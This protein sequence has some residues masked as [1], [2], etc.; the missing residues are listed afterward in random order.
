M[1]DLQLIET[2]AEIGLELNNEK[3]E[4]IT[5]DP[6]S[7][8]TVLCSLP[9]ARVVDPSEA[10]LLGSPLGDVASVSDTLSGKIHALEV[11]GDRLG[12]MSAHDALILLRNSFSIPKLLH[13][14]RTSPAFLSPALATYD[15]SLQSI[16]SSITNIQFE[17]DDPAWT[18]A[19]LPIGVGGLG[20]R[21]AVQLAPSAFLASAAATRDLVCQILPP[22]LQP[23]PTLYEEDALSLWSSGH[24]I[25]PSGAAACVQ[26]SWDAPLVSNAVDLLLQN[27]PHDVARA[28]L[29]A[30]SAKESGAWL[31][32]LPVS[33]LGLR[34]DD[35]T[36]RVAVGLRLGSVLCRP[37]T[38]QHCEV[39][40]DQLGTHG[41]SCKR[42]EGRHHRHSAVNDILH[43]A[44]R[45]AKV[46]ARLEPSGLTRSDGKRPDGVTL[47]P[48]RRG[49]PLV[50]DAT[51]PDTLAFSYRANATA[52]A[53]EVAAMA[54]QKKLIKYDSLAPNY[55]I[56]PVAIESLGA[57]GPLSRALLKDLGRRIK[58]S[59]GEARAHEYLVQRLA[60][61]VQRGNA[62][63]IMGTMGDPGQDFFG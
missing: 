27:A 25:P 55:D 47:V 22:R 28:R 34:M 12:Y 38:C 20:I 33:S 30:V 36:I 39:E 56:A 58:E 44:L 2:V 32:A 7:R 49:K 18:Q 41:L 52:G 35:S 3:S 13:I 53:G 9:G 16:V 24:H 14:L 6:V 50:W 37:H 4:I 48:W 8:G 10:C 54:E 19:T 63:S 26:K 31:K 59:T 23:L 62:V 29:L 61:A 15:E 45:S 21:S 43:R 17:P 51:C 57:I 42:S 1:Q 11:M 46:P 5:N 60:V 40:V